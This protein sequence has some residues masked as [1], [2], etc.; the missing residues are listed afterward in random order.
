MTATGT[1][2]A[3]SPAAAAGPAAT[4]PDPVV[5]PSRYSAPVSEDPGASH[6]VAPHAMPD[7]ATGSDGRL[8]SVHVAPPPDKITAPDVPDVPDVVDVPSTKQWPELPQATDESDAVPAGTGSAV[9]L[10]APVC[11]NTSGV[12]ADVVPTAVQTVALG[13]VIEVIE[14]SLAGVSSV[15]VV[16]AER[17]RIAPYEAPPTVRLPS[18]WQEVVDPLVAHSTEVSDPAVEGPESFTHLVGV[19]DV[20]ESSEA[21][22]D[23]A[24][25]PT[26]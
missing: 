21:A 15:Q 19:A 2:A 3:S 13:Q 20:R 18:A 16:G 25:V 22:G 9:K 5:V 14:P 8:S 1:P 23:D 4:H 12:P 26:A 7:N 10:V 11:H 17:E 24:R 6:N